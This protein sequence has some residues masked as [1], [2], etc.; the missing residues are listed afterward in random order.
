MYTDI[1]QPSNKAVDLDFKMDSY[2]GYAHVI[3]NM[4]K[5]ISFQKEKFCSLSGYHKT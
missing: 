5:K 1:R 3:Y 4:G 2:K